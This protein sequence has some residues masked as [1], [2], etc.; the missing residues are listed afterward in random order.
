MGD[1]SL[2]ENKVM[3]MREEPSASFNERRLI[4]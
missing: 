1:G 2:Q 3:P 4:V